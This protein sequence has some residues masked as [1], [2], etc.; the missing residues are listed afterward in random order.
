MSR[1]T[2]RDN[3]REQEEEGQQERERGSEPQ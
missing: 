2:G 3:R 1:R